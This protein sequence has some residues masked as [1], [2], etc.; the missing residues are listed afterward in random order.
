MEKNCSYTCYTAK[1]L[2][3]HTE[4]HRAERIHCQETQYGGK[5]DLIL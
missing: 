5:P 3:I 4:R 1:D 2:K